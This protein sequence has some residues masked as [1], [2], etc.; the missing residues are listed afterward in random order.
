VCIALYMSLLLEVFGY[1]QIVSIM[2][3]GD[4]AKKL[5]SVE[6]LFAQSTILYVIIWTKF[7]DATQKT[8]GALGSETDIAGPKLNN[9]K[10]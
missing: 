2:S 10:W 5:P 8:G 1:K 6:L 3:L 9:V 7:R 4:A